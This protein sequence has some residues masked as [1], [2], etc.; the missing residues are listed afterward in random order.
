MGIPVKRIAKVNIKSI[1]CSLLVHQ[2]CHFVTEGIRLVRQISLFLNPCHLLLISFSM[3]SNGFQDWLF[4]PSHFWR[5]RWG[6]LPRSFP[7]SFPIVFPALLEDR[8]DIYFL[9]VLRSVSSLKDFQ[10]WPNSD[11]NHLAWHLWLYAVRLHRHEY[12]QY[13]QCFLAGYFFTRGKFS[14]FHT[15][16]LVLTA[17]DFCGHFLT[18]KTKIDGFRLGHFYYRYVCCAI[19][20]KASVFSHLYSA[21][22]TNRITELWELEGTSRDRQVQLPWQSRFP[23]Q[24]A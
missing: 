17:W 3:C 2:A 15:F 18:V 11:I 23:R 10:G 5:S 4:A 6:W 24:I 9:P 22:D 1:R 7:Q 20:S 13:S 8:S 12:V 19:Q 16:P 14:V 21:A